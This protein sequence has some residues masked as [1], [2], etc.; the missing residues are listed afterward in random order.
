MANNTASGTDVDYDDPVGGD[1]DGDGDNQTS[2]NVAVF[3]TS[4]TVAVKSK[5]PNALGLY[6]MSGNVFE[7]TFD[8]RGSYRQYRGGD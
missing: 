5:S 6:D 1:F 7:E 4:A 8:E 3:N 2:S